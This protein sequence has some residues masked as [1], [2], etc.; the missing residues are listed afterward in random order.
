MS[1][2][3]FSS[4]PSEREMSFLVNFLSGRDYKEYNSLQKNNMYKDPEAWA[5]S[6]VKGK[7]LEWM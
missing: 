6:F 2:Y 5:V 7:I 1:L 4:I 3:G